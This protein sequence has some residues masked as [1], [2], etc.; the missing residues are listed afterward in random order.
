MDVMELLEP[1]TYENMHELKP[2]EWIW[3]NRMVE[4]RVHKRTL[5]TETIFEPYGFRQ[6]DILDLKGFGVYNNQPFMLSTTGGRT[7]GYAEW[8]YFMVDRFYR[9][10]RQEE[11]KNDI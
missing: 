2:G 6:I 11:T 8:V 9:F 5:D 10:K 4:K 3:N 1:I 7:Y